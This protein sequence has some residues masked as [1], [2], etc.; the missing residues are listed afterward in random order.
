VKHSGFALIFSLVRMR[1]GKE[2][3]GAR[4]APELG[5]MLASLARRLAGYVMRNPGA[6]QW[7]D[8]E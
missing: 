7:L 5:H 8:N 6:K 3:K 4:T 1:A 2:K